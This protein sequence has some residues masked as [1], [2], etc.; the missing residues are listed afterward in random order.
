MAKRIAFLYCILAVQQRSQRS[1]GRAPA[2]DHHNS[3]YR[4]CQAVC[5]GTGSANVMR[6]GCRVEAFAIRV[7]RE[8]RKAAASASPDALAGYPF[9]ASKSF[10]NEI[11]AFTASC[12]TAL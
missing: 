4:F 10:M 5:S 11:S 9:L 7:P 2:A 3:L 6:A 8:S 1:S 12:V